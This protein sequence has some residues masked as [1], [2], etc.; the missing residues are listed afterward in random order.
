MDNTTKSNYLKLTI[1][2]WLATL[3]SS[4]L[5]LIISRELFHAE[6]DWIFQVRLIVL[7]VALLASLL[8]HELRPLLKYV[9]VLSMLF[10]LEYV[11]GWIGASQFWQRAFSGMGFSV[12]MASTQ[13]LRLIVSLGMVMVM[14]NL[15]KKPALF[16]LTRGNPDAIAE[17]IPLIMTQPAPWSRLGWIL[18]ACISV[19]TL[20]FL[21]LGGTPEGNFASKLLPLLP[22][23]LIFAA[24][25]AFSEEMSYRAAPLSVLEE[26][27]GKNQSLLLTAFFFG[28]GHFYGVPYGLTGVIMASLLGWFLGK[29]MLETRGFGWA[30]FIHFLQD[31][32]I[33]AFMALGTI[34]PGG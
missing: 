14:M 12:S 16:F 13:A 33:F 5:L 34:T 32:M 10:L 11:A 18:A 8:R 29:S 15:Q 3:L 9:L 17:P 27:L 1:T 23:V 7:G 26:P 30:W 20:A 28:I 19:G 24:M 25:N 21:L 4:N 6:P 22:A 2:A 31:V